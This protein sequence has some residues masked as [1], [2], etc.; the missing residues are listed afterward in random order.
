MKYAIIENGK[1][2]NIAVSDAPLES[3][4][5]ASET[6]NIGDEYANGAFTTPPPDLV[7][8][9]NFA[10]TLRNALLAECDWTQVDDAPVDKAVWA[11]YRQELRDITAQSGF[12]LNINWPIK[13]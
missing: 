3:N 11:A 2:V 5:V 4:W 6:A 13:P 12:P 1:V 8:A 9:S 10:R 7:A